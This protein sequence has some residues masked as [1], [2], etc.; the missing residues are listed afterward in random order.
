MILN[1]VVLQSGWC[2]PAQVWVILSVFAVVLAVL[3][4]PLCWYVPVGLPTWLLT[5]DSC[6]R[7]ISQGWMH[8]FFWLFKSYYLFST[9]PQSE[10]WKGLQHTLQVVGHYVQIPHLDN[11]CCLFLLFCFLKGLRAFSAFYASLRKKDKHC[12]GL[13]FFCPNIRI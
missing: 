8:D 11:V 3:C 13:V 1:P 10:L 12:A 9:A 7:V 5:S 4:L 2:L 6:G